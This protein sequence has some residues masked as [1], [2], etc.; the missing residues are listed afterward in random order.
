MKSFVLALFAAL[1]C[2]SACLGQTSRW[3]ETMEQWRKER[4]FHNLKA[5]IEGRP[6]PYPPAAPVAPEPTAVI[7]FGPTTEGPPYQP[8]PI[9]A[10]F[11]AAAKLLVFGMVIAFCHG[12]GQS[13][14]A[15]GK[16]WQGCFMSG[17]VALVAYGFAATARP[18]DTMTTAACALGAFVGC[19]A[20][21]TTERTC[22]PPP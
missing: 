18:P 16:P 3:A 21:F 9:E 6:L 7:E 20:A 1:L 5:E 13:M 15:A 17:F 4:A 8:G 22:K 10:V 19:V 12:M 14:G 11:N 2:A